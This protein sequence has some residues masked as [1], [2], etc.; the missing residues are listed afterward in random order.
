MA[1]SGGDGSI[2]LTT[3]VDQK[4]ITKGMK[5]LTSVVVKGFAVIGAAAATA[6]VAITKQAVSAYAD[7]EQLVGGVET[8]FK[9]SAD[10]VLKY[11]EDAF[12]TTGM[13]AN[14]YMENVTAFSASL[15]SATKGDTEKAA[16]I[17]NSAMIS[18]SDN[19]NKMGSSAESVQLAFQGFAKQQYM[20][21]DNLKLGY[22]GTKTEMERLLKDAEAFSGVKYD[23]NNLADVYTA[24][25]VIQEKLGIAGT[26][27][28]EAEKTISGSA[29]MMKAAWENVLT[30]V[31]GGGDLEK[32]INNFV[33]S[34]SKLFE[35]ISPVVQR[36]LMG[37]GR[38]IEQ[39]AP[40]LVQNVASAL[41]Q[42]IPSLLNAVYQ[43]I[44]GLAKG[45]FEGI[46]ALFTG[47]QGSITAQL[48][49]EMAEASTETDAATESMDGLTEATE[50]AG[51]AAKK[52]VA[53]FDDLQIISDTASD[54]E[55]IGDIGDINA[56]GITDISNVL[57]ETEEE[58]S[59][60]AEILQ[61]QFEKIAE[62]A[63][64]IWNSE[65]IQAFVSAGQS[66]LSTF[67]S[68]CTTMWNDIGTNATSTWQSIQPSLQNTLTNLTNLW[69]LFWQ[70]FGAAVDTWGQP[71]IGSIST[72]FNSIWETAISPAIE[73]ITGT[74]QDFTGILLKLW[75]EH[76]SPLLNNLGEF[77]Q[78][79]IELFQSIYD[80]VLEPII[81]P[82]LEMLSWLWDK[83]LS[84][85][86]Y[87]V[88]DF[89]MS[90]I[91]GALEIYNKFIQPLV[92]SLL[93]KLAP[94]WAFISSLFIGQIGTILGVIS[95][96]ATS[97]FEVLTGII[98]FI[99]GV[100]TGNWEKA[101]EG[102]KSIFKGIWDA[103][104]GVA[105]GVIN[106][107]I[108]V[109][110][111]FIAGIN[112]INFDV[113]EWIP[114]IGGKQ[115]GFDIPKIPKLAQGT[116]VPPNKEFMAILGDNTR[117]HEVVSPI[118]TMKQAF[119]EAM[120]EMGGTSGGDTTII[121]EMDS[122]EFGHAVIK[123]G[124]REAKRLGTRLVM[125]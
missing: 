47:K 89:V 112:K 109:L 96:L 97:L 5:N 124:Q 72:L 43:M 113:P 69:T 39:V 29:A 6:T 85:L 26:T 60:F 86:V 81:S 19:V 119:M 35:N 15:I 49:T 53:P 105:K 20:L 24:I 32:S 80:N 40:M 110:N 83:H 36:A 56:G 116:V 11:A 73:L 52:A 34:I 102:I 115:W 17:A 58:A 28:K 125:A 114:V 48:N 106:L 103:L 37:I 76:G 120:L 30:A 95:D 45:I 123:Q 122:R 12:F 108:D 101:W 94:A 68:F 57:L 62:K 59:G 78:R 23:I 4:G 82:F 117:E 121:L 9:G 74:W 55:S 14:K 90:L 87:A 64:Q 18:I 67:W 33:Y 84:K 2:I 16:E 71:I 8:L 21:L 79:T 118:S 65:P 7:Y 44:V 75:E 70:D 42:S 3:K 46:K 107:I 54:M 31:A 99:V 27:A 38:L 22:G 10:K 91:N 25:G 50:E 51:K 41:I 77:A 1:I 13:S 111:S 63:S 66:Y 92:S 100:F 104:E 93:E 88:G 61:E 98:D